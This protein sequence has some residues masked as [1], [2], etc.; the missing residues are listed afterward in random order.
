MSSH[1]A[2]SKSKA[3]A[4]PRRLAPSL[5]GL[6]LL[7]PIFASGLGFFVST[8]IELPIWLLG[9][10]VG[11]LTAIPIALVAFIKTSGIES[12][13][14]EVEQWIVHTAQESGD[15]IKR[16]GDG[17][18]PSIDQAIKT[19]SHTLASAKAADSDQQFLQSIL[20]SLPDPL[21]VLNA[22]GLVEFCNSRFSELLRFTSRDG[23]IGYGLTTLVGQ[24][25]PAWYR[26]I[27]RDGSVAA[28]EVELTT[29]DKRAVKVLATGVL[30]DEK[31]EDSRVLLLVRDPSQVEQ[32]GARLEAAQAKVAESEAVFQNLFDAIED[33]ITVLGLNG[34]IL[35]ANRAART[36]FGKRLVG[37]KC[38]R[39]FRMRDAVCDEC[40]AS[41]T[42]A[43]K[44]STVVEHRIFGNAITRIN[45]YPLLGKNGEVKAILN[46]K[47]DVT[48]ERQLEDLK[49]S[50][51]AAVSHELRTPLTSIIGF[52]KLNRRRM[53]RHLS[54]ILETAP[55]KARVAFQQIL[56]DMD[57]MVSE[58]ERLGRLVNDILDLSKLEAGR[59]QLHMA[60]VDI[61]KVI[62]GSVAATS[63][64]WRA[65]EL[66]MDCEFDFEVPAIWGDADRLAQ[67]VVNLLSNA[68][69]FTAEGTIRVAVDIDEFA[70]TVSVS[71]T[72]RGIPPDQVNGIF[73]KF[74][75]VDGISDGRP[76]GTGLG[77]PICR[78]LINLH[79]GRIWVESTLGVGTAIK[80]TVMRAD[81]R[82]EPAKVQERTSFTGEFEIPAK[83][84]SVD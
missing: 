10:F 3:H 45:T 40:P 15:E 74:R 49:A 79:G 80:F 58:G 20:D 76:L 71:D 19:V 72:G 83:P 77:L 81:R 52:N 8:H 59:M 22:S 69:K 4:M 42:Y 34:E 64:L 78:E 30:L 5:I 7:A 66:H 12:Q 46:H 1:N 33:P 27:K 44:R 13:L 24:E 2:R 41:L 57:I 18:G 31:P 53:T 16:R 23:P 50:F 73:E 28:I 56:D 65:K 84:G 37:Q 36:M 48:N 51:L 43:N 29:P 47:R 39:A 14:N 35:Q 63:A 38:Y 9:L 62:N 61:V 26:Q 68:T 54:S 60:D 55:H 70:V 11:T 6:T 25:T 32:L 82:V 21:V 67:V 17:Q 75:Q